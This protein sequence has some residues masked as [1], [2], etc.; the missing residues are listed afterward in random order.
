MASVAACPCNRWSEIRSPG[1]TAERS[2]WRCAPPFAAAINVTTKICLVT[3]SMP[4][5][6][7]KSKTAQDR[8]EKTDVPHAPQPAALNI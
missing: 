7:P 5:A 8:Q 3:R 1:P 2:C 4:P 6:P